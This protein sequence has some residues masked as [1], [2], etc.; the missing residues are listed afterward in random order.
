[1]LRLVPEQWLQQL[2]LPRPKRGDRG[3]E[4]VG[5][6]LLELGNYQRANS[7]NKL[8][9][10]WGGTTTRSCLFF[11]FLVLTDNVFLPS[12]CLS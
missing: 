1:M 9:K 6:E 4:I 10:K 7:L 11:F 2:E 12:L 8:F 3:G 5:E